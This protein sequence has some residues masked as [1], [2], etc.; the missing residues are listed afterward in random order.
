MGIPK[1][2]FDASNAIPH[3]STRFLQRDELVR[4]GLD[5]RDFGETGWRFAE[6]TSLWAFIDL[7]AGRP[8]RIPPDVRALFPI[9][10]SMLHPPA[11]G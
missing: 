7:A 5:T 10:P 2:L 9:E 4:F 6:A 11:H 1:A 8:T 3:E